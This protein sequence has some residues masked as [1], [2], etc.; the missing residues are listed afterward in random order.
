MN[1]VELRKGSKK[2]LYTN[3]GMYVYIDYHLITTHTQTFCCVQRFAWHKCMFSF[4]F[5]LLP[6]PIPKGRNGIA[7][8]VHGG[9][10]PRR[11]IFVLG[12]DVLVLLKEGGR[13]FP[14]LFGLRQL[15]LALGFQQTTGLLFFRQAFRGVG[16]GRSRREGG[17]R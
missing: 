7:R 4:S 2:D 5:L 11:P 15:G 16:G 3:M 13:L 17:R 14:I 9:R 12:P 10:R 1:T 6:V 8:L